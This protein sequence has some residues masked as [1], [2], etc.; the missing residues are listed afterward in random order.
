MSLSFQYES[1]LSR[2]KTRIAKHAGIDIETD[3]LVEINDTDAVPLWGYVESLE[4]FES[5]YQRVIKPARSRILRKLEN[6]ANLMQ[7]K[8]YKDQVFEVVF[9][10]YIILNDCEEF[11]TKIGP[12]ALKNPN[13]NMALGIFESAPDWRCNR[14][15]HKVCSQIFRKLYCKVNPHFEQTMISL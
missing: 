12:D 11:F 4:N 13:P 6:G 15:L 2:L 3:L 8:I 5:N 9:N 1:H 10:Y 7:D 14:F